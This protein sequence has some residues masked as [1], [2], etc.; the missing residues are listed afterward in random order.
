VLLLHSYLTLL[1]T[2]IVIACFT[3]VSEPTVELVFLW[4]LHANSRLA[5][6][7]QYESQKNFR[8]ELLANTHLYL[9]FW[10]YHDT[11]FALGYI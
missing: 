3:T 5:C 4:L 9:S 2:V 1:T 11:V 10:L 6:D 7:R 8:Y